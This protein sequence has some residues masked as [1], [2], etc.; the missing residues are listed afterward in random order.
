MPMKS[1]PEALNLRSLILQNLEE[2]VLLTTKEEREP[3]LN[4]VLVGAGP[5]GT[6]LAG[7]L[8]ELRNY[9]LTRDYPEL[10]KDHMSVYLVDGL[11][12]VLASMSE[13]GFKRI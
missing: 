2:A 8:A 1:V 4:F 9:I 13:E 10:E 11:P 5:T 3:F 7:A 12:R 6:E